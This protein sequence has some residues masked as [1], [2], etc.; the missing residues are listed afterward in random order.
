MGSASRGLQSCS[1]S[2]GSVRDRRE[3]CAFLLGLVFYKICTKIIHK[4]YLGLRFGLVCMERREPHHN[5]YTVSLLTDNIVVS[6]KVSRT[7]GA[8]RAGIGL[9]CGFG[10]FM[11]L[12]RQIWGSAW[13]CGRKGFM[14]WIG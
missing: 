14:R 3:G 12:S 8:R 5:R 7:R 9:K 11:N 13:L 2:N 1:G 4:V 6:S 10:D